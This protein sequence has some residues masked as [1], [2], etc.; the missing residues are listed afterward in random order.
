MEITKTPELVKI[1]T[2]YAIEKG[3]GNDLLGFCQYHLRGYISIR[4][5]HDVTLWNIADL[6]I[7]NCKRVIEFIS[8]GK[9]E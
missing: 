6:E 2:D 5:S 3:W 7:E 1:Y 4:K 8:G 9:N